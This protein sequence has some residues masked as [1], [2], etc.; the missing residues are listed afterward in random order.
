MGPDADEASRVVI[1]LAILAISSPIMLTS[2]LAN[3]QALPARLTSALENH[4][5]GVM[6]LW[7]QKMFITTS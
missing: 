2:V 3:T 5:I 6:Y 4:L 7:L 1:T